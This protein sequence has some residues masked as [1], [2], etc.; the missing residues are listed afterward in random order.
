V[1]EHLER[2]KSALADRYT[3]ERELG[4][5]GNAV[6]YLAHDQ[7]HDRQV[8]LKVLLP[9]LALAVRTERFLREIQIAAKLSHPHILGLHD[10]GAVEGFLYYVMPYV[11]GESLRDRL[12]RERRLPLEDALQITGDVAEALSY[13]HDHDIVHRDIKPENILLQGGHAMVADFGI[14]RALSAA[15]SQSVTQTGVAVGTPVYMS[16]EQGAGSGKLDGRS[17]VY[18]LACVVYEML[19]G[20]PPFTGQTPQEV[21]AQHALKL[22]PPL[23]KWRPE[24]PAGVEAALSTAL[25]KQPA[26]RFA[27]VAEFA[28]ALVK[29]G[30]S[31]PG[32]SRSRRAP[33][34][35]LLALLAVA[36]VGAGA[37]V[38]LRGR[39]SAAP[40]TIAV[41]PFV[42]L[43]GNPENEY[44]SDGL[45]E[46]LI[47]ALVR[48]PGLRVRGRT[49]SF[50]FKGK[51]LSL[52]QIGD[53]LHV[54]TVLEGSLRTAGNRLRVTSQL[55]RVEDG[56]PLW[57]EIYDR[58]LAGVQD[59][60]AV[61][62]ELA[63]AIVGALQVKLAPASA[64]PDNPAA[65]QLYLRGRFF[66]NKGTVQGLN[67][68]LE[69]FNAAIAQDSAYARAYA[70]MAD[71]YEGLLF[72][73][74]LPRSEAYPKARAA[75]DRA[76]A[77]DPQL[78]EAYV[79]RGL[80][81]HRYETDWSGA[82][83][84]FSRALS[85][86][87]GYALGHL[88]Y[89]VMMGAQGRFP[90]AIREHRR[91]AELDPLSTLVLR[92]YSFLLTNARQFAPAAEQARQALE[93]EPTSASGHQV[94]GDA[95]LFQGR[96][97]DAVQE[98]QTALDL[99]GGRGRVA[100]N[101]GRMGVAYARAGRRDE[102]LK[103][104]EDM[105]RRVASGDTAL[106]GHEISLARLYSA[107]GEEDQAFVWLERAYQER[108]YDLN[109][110][111]VSPYFDAL[112][113]DPRYPQLLKRLGL[114]GSSVRD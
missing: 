41:L 49:S 29:P 13:A 6:V 3:I 5:G 70:G 36:V 34:G 53:S 75:A 44:L 65:Y 100:P 82:E 25:A 57:S 61:Q 73:R 9:E 1:P 98:F 91:A 107:L 8:A 104:L 77:L 24:V 43:S 15:G 89:G 31:A 10:S 112:R 108:D 54:A 102:A 46:E 90:E 97:A 74:Y 68:A 42:N 51:G 7:K 20:Q 59:V 23:R 30:V 80:L 55:I 79:S 11:E 47:S 84:D 18:S 16:P 14:A 58:E 38:A 114:E 71:A 111:R 83:Q 52:R 56:Y 69:F 95:Y 85:L 92:T 50:F 105:K 109:T 21:L 64:R 62:E 28:T 63:H 106:I 78:A 12:E 110:L 33:V 22:V 39:A 93:L 72:F 101:L 86:N 103:I 81:R 60:I 94:L 113:S 99:L 4:H 35:W 67:R 26:E 19:A 37:A 76:I 40:A 96:F 27:T 48:I 66:W 32:R 88:R 87:P 45:S 17:D 2:L